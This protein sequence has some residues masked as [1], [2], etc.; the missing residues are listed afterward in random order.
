MKIYALQ[1]RSTG[2]VNVF[3]SLNPTGDYLVVGE[4]DVDITLPSH[5]E[6]KAL[7]EADNAKYKEDRIQRLKEELKHLE[8]AA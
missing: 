6:V 3:L 7:I 5:D 2:F 1:S 4:Y 8:G